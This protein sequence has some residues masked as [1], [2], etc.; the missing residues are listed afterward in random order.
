MLLS[1]VFTLLTLAQLGFARS[2][3]LRRATKIAS[4]PQL[5]QNT[6]SL[7]LARAAEAS[8]H[9]SVSRPS[10]F[11]LSSSS[12]RRS[13]AP[14][15]VRIRTRTDALDSHSWEIGTRETAL[16]ELNAPNAFLYQGST[17]PPK[18]HSSDNVADVFASVNAVLAQ[19]PAG[20]VPFFVDGA[21]GDPCSMYW[22]QFS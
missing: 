17:I 12:L 21:A 5:S 14:D 10:P 19:K 20:N 3:S 15:I 8:T 7:V 16:L 13:P 1:S 22:F 9:R 2:G 6:L 4:S 18:L 11:S